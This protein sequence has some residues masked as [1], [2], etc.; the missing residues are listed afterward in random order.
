MVIK[1]Q[2]LLNAD[3]T[4]STS[5]ST[6]EICNLDD[7]APT[8]TLLRMLQREKPS[9]SEVMTYPS[10][11]FQLN[12][13]ADALAKYKAGAKNRATLEARSP[14]TISPLQLHESAREY[15]QLWQ[16]RER[17]R[18]RALDAEESESEQ[19]ST[20]RSA[21]STRNFTRPG[22]SSHSSD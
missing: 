14:E 2:Q 6:A 7:F 12:E 13:L 1:L 8:S 20:V 22:R 4:P 16:E 21:I 18:K 17:K 15:E 9:A 10:L 3:D 19:A 5:S 11:K